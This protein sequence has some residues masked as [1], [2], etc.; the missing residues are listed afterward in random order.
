MAA[1]SISDLIDNCRDI[2][3]DDSS[4][5]FL[6]DANWTKILNT[7]ERKLSRY[8]KIS[9]EVTIAG[10]GVQSYTI[11][12]EATNVKWDNVFCRVGTTHADDTELKEYDVNDGK[13]H[14]KQVIGSGEY[15]VIW[16]KRPYILGTDELTDDA[17]E[18]L[19]KLAE[20]EWINYA[21]YRRADYAQWASLN[22][23]DTSVN[24]MVISK[25]S[26]Q[27]DLK[28]LGKVLGEGTD[29]SNLGRY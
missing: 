27:E 21:I 20:I 2:V 29:I 15:I 13:I 5:Q 24:Q 12:A 14:T 22:R 7:C 4:E 17:L 16:I 28:E 26:L 8:L 10:T 25:Q 18:I 6:T 9:D 1:Q 3:G 19:Y 23:S 11:P